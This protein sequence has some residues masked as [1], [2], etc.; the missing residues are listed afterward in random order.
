MELR[1]T[2]REHVVTRLSQIIESRELGQKRL[3]ELSGIRQPMISNILLGKV[4]PSRAQLDAL[5]QALWLRLNDFLHDTTSQKRKLVGYFATPL[6]AVVQDANR[7]KNLRMLVEKVKKLASE[8][9]EE[10]SLYWP[11]DYTHPVTNSDVKPETVYRMDR[12][13][14]SALDFVVL[15]LADP[16]YG[17]GQ[18]NEIA[19]QAGL[20]AI[21]LIPHGVS[22]MMRGSFL[23]ATDVPFAGNLETGIDVDE[24][25]LRQ[26]LEQMRLECYH[27]SALYS[28]LRDNEFGTRL[29]GLV[30]KRR[31]D[32]G[33]FAKD[34]GVSLGFVNALF[35]EP[36]RVSNPS[37]Y[38]LQKMAS[39][40]RVTVSDLVGDSPNSDAVSDTSVAEWWS[41][42]RG[43]KGI[44]AGI[45]IQLRDEYLEAHEQSRGAGS[46][47]ASL[48]VMTKV[49]WQ[50]L[51]RQECNKSGGRSNDPGLFGSNAI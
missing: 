14:A 9:E 27:Q 28:G 40:L 15:F 24:H 49:Q 34:L 16:S 50:Q 11:G 46:A 12:A 10:L 1:P 22:R 31:G 7:E 23:R 29:R 41:W 26:A 47:R 19:S 45:A 48:G 42:L 32:Y 4:T 36:L 25:K 8:D 2:E 20:P 51:Y 38:L 33:A 13:Q 5:T 3:A 39:L 35:E 6:T 37:T 44:D 18:E 21:R 43:T 17:V 30:N